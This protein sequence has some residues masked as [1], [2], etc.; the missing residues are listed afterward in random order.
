MSH[1]M[2]WHRGAGVRSV[3]FVVGP[4]LNQVTKAMSSSA[5]AAENSNARACSEG[6]QRVLANARVAL[7]YRR[8]T[9]S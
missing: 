5:V 1:T 3:A 7:V 8:M 2:Q 6:S 9:A 4:R